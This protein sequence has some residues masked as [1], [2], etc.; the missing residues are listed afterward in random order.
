[1]KQQMNSEQKRRD[2]ESELGK[3]ETN[4]TSFKNFFK[5]KGSKETSKLT[6]K[7]DIEAANH[8]IED[9]RKLI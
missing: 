2:N 1:M 5:S 6:L 8:S 4:K 7:A 3:L 9:Y